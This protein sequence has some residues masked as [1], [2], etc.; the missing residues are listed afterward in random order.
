MPNGIY[1]LPVSPNTDYVEK[2]GVEKG[3]YILSV[4]RITNEKGFDVL[5]KA[6]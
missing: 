2:I 3:I 6:F 4:G 1:D 5:I